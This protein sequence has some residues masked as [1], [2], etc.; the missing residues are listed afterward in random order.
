MVGGHRRTCHRRPRTQPLC[1]RNVS[2]GPV[3]YQA[4]SKCSRRRSCWSDILSF[5]STSNRV[6]SQDLEQCSPWSRFI[7]LYDSKWSK[8]VYSPAKVP[9]L[10][11][12]NR[13]ARELALQWYR[14]SFPA[15]TM[16]LEPRVYFDWSRDSLV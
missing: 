6:M 5:S 16:E 14:L 10:L 11:H 4:S 15:P 12:V 2:L 8:A 13:E 3:P 7:K 9:V 1:R